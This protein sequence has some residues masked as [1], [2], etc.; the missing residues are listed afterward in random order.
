MFNITCSGQSFRLPFV[1][2]RFRV[3]VYIPQPFPFLAI[4]LL[5]QFLVTKYGNENKRAVFSTVFHP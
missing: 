3:T 4:P 5:L 2:I 1:L